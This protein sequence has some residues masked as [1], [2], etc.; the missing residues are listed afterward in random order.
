[1]ELVTDED[2]VQG[3]FSGKGFLTC[4]RV[5]PRIADQNLINRTVCSTSHY[6]AKRGPPSQGRP[7]TYAGT[8]VYDFIALISY[9]FSLRSFL[10][11]TSYPETT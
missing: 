10:I 2:Y 4:D 7:F 1:M 9:P 6:G 11:S 8:I 5:D 3:T